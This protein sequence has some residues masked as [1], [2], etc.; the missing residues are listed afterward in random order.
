MTG[1]VGLDPPDIARY[2]SSG[3]STAPQLIEE[4]NVAKRKGPPWVAWA[5][6]RYHGRVVDVFVCA[7]VSLDAAFGVVGRFGQFHQMM[8]DG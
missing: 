8:H 1:G 2:F 6:S 7:A 4:F 5:L 3:P